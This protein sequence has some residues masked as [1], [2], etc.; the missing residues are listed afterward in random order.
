MNYTTYPGYE[1]LEHPD[2][3]R[4]RRRPS[5]AKLKRLLVEAQEQA[6]LRGGVTTEEAV[7]RIRE[8]RDE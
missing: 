6:R 2:Y 8:L 4:A 3:P 7:A 5:K 1:A